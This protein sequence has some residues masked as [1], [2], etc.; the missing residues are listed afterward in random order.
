MITITREEAKQTRL[1]LIKMYNMMLKKMSGPEID[2]CRDLIET[3]RS[4]LEPPNY[5]N[6][7]EWKYSPVT[8]E[9]LDDYWYSF[10]LG[11]TKAE[12]EEKNNVW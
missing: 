8:G 4:K 6:R 5:G 11:L 12:L 7:K 1:L 10:H 2:Q 3:L 9:P